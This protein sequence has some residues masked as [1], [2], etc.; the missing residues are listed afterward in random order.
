TI[1]LLPGSP[2][3]NAGTATAGL[4]TDQRGE[5]LDIPVDIGAFQSQGF[6]LA[7]APGTTPQS[8]PTGEGFANPLAVTVFALNPVEPVAGGIVSFTVTPD[9]DRGAG[10]MLSASSAVIGADHHAQV[11]ATANDLVGTYSVTASTTDG[12]NLPRIMLT[13]LPNNEVVLN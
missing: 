6:V 4:T 9:Q 2:A 13:N 5:P 7:A 10:A 1:A 3:L 11:T 12:F 8:T